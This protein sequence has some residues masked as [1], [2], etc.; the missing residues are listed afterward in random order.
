VPSGAAQLEQAW[1][2]VS[3]VVRSAG[4]SGRRRPGGRTPEYDGLGGAVAGRRGGVSF[5][6]RPTVLPPFYY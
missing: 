1:A 4:G 5:T 6:S 2:P 3:G